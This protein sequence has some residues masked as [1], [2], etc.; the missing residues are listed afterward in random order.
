MNSITSVMLSFFALC[1]T[2]CPVV[3]SMNL[4]RIIIISIFIVSISGCAS[5]NLTNRDNLCQI[6]RDNDDIY[7]AAID[8]EK[9][10]NV[11]VQI[12][13]AIMH[14][15]SRFIDDAR[16]GKDY[17]LG[18]IPWGYKSSAYG[19]AQ[20]KDGVWEDYIRQTGNSGADRDD[21]DDALDFMGWYIR[22]TNTINKV[23]VWNTKELYL[24]YH[25]GWGGYKRA[26]W[27]SKAWL[28]KVADKV[29]R[30]ASL[31]GTQYRG[32]KDSLDDSWF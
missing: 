10:W 9:R 25:E 11:P 21:I 8:M 3:N 22:K 30:R 32:C 1:D 31:Y 13:M 14:Q 17:L 19:Y 15:E 29:H 27:K 26:T 18:F 4:A 2:N 7:D 28:I 23:S 20:A 24:N 5:G 6:F 16:P 12:P